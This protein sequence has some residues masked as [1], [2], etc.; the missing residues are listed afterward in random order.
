M[1]A[2]NKST[3]TT[4][5]ESDLNINW[6]PGHMKKTKEQILENIKLVD[7]VL[8]IV[9][10]RAPYSSSNPDIDDMIKSVPKVVVLNKEDLADFN[11]T[12]KW[13]EYYKSKGHEAAMINSLSG[14]GLN[15]L[16]AS[17]N[18]KAQDLYKKL[19]GRGRRKRP[20]R[21]MVVG[22]P[23]V[24]KSSIIN[25]IVG[26][27]SAQTGDRPGVTKGKQWVK[28][29][30]DLELLDTPGVLWPKIED[31]I[32]AL[33]LAFLGSIKDEVMELEEIA[34]ELI[35]YL[36]KIKPSIYLERF[37]IDTKDMAPIEIADAI[38]MV[39]GYLLPGN[40]IDYFRLSSSL[41]M[42]FRAGKLGKITLEIPEDIIILNEAL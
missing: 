2:K 11:K 35:S 37:E 17:L 33:K 32:V 27:K 40:K 3:N 8:E 6:Y 12:Q 16:L 36:N 39:R 31:N 18:I 23:N 19:E 34:I 9:D 38:A 22:I 26:K 1:K 13:I 28:L 21:V 10:A 14:K 7:V 41:L 4:K 15:E 24:G 30:G 29:K 20:L 42:E 25:R 5:S